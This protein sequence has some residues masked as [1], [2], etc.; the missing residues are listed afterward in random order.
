MDNTSLLCSKIWNVIRKRSSPV[1]MP[2]PPLSPSDDPD[3]LALAGADLFFAAPE[4]LAQGVLRPGSVKE[5]C[6]A[7]AGLPPD[8]ALIARGA[9]LSYTAAVVPQAPALVIDMAGIGGIEVNAEDLWVRVGAGCSWHRLAEAL[10]PH[11]LRVPVAA[12]TS[13]L[14]STVGGAISQGLP[15]TMEAVLGLTVAL[16]DG[17]LLTTGSAALAG[18]TPFNRHAGPDLTGPFIGDCGTLGIKVQ[19]VLRLV[20]APCTDFASF[21]F[22]DPVTMVAAMVEL[23]RDL[24]LSSMGIDPVRT[25]TALRALPAS[26]AVKGGWAALWQA[27]S[28]RGAVRAALDLLRTGAGAKAQAAGWSLHLTAEH[29][30]EAGARAL[31]RAARA[32]IRQGKPIAPGIPRASRA[33]PFS[34]RGALGP[35]AERWVPVHGIV[36]LSQA[37]PAMT[38]LQAY[39]AEHRARMEAAGVFMAWLTTSRHGA[40][41]FEPMLFWPDGLTPVHR[42]YLDPGL[43]AQAEGRAAPAATRAL[44]AELRAGLCQVLDGHGATHLQLGRY[45]GYAGLLEPGARRFLAALKAAQDPGGRLNPGALGLG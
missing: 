12:P 44:V 25:A 1:S 30:T 18:R 34:V 8:R 7:L 38:A 36:P 45:Y 29:P 16:P 10:A 17:S 41:L 33:R 2:Q 21:R 35:A 4:G 15:G 37:V 43:V 42:R 23:Q 40:V 14:H 19:A 5:L 26:E 13:G 24:G 27:G 11:G 31:I 22:G 20:R 3:A 39:A 9:G 6:A 32:R 28:L